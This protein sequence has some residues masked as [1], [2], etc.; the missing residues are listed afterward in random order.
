MHHA[1]FLHTQFLCRLVLS[2]HVLAC[3]WAVLCVNPCFCCL[4]DVIVCWA[5][6]H[7]DLQ[8]LQY[9]AFSSSLMW[10]HSETPVNLLNFTDH[11][12]YLQ[13]LPEL[14]WSRITCF[15]PSAASRVSCSSFPHF[16]SRRHTVQS[17]QLDLI[18][19]NLS[20]VVGYFQDRQLKTI[21]INKLS[22]K[23][24]FVNVLSRSIFV[25]SIG[26]IKLLESDPKLWRLNIHLGPHWLPSLSEFFFRERV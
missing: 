14:W 24:Y 21:N 11:R 12:A 16:Y 8:Y 23:V 10:I 1:V 5:L 2:V 22:I 26:K 13:I 7:A 4:S 3:R 15:Y 18:S 17:S 20:V 6:L 25:I 19:V 9:A